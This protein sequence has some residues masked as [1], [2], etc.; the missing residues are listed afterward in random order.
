MWVNVVI[1]VGTLDVD[2]HF[3]ALKLVHI[4]FIK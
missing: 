2:N 1:I 3:S 4:F